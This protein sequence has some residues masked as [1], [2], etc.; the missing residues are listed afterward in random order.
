MRIIEDNYNKF[1]IRVRCCECGSLIELESK[2][3]LSQ[4]GVCEEN[5]YFGD[6]PCCERCNIIQIE[7]TD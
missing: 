2:E 6:C 3:E 1:P 4:T 7:L 5:E